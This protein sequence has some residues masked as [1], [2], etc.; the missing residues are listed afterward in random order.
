MSQQRKFSTDVLICQTKA[1]LL[2][3]NLALLASHAFMSLNQCITAHCFSISLSDTVWYKLPQIH[4]N[5]NNIKTS[6]AGVLKHAFNLF[7]LQI[8][9]YAVRCALGSIREHDH[10][11]VHC[12]WV[13]WTQMQVW[14]DW[15]CCTYCKNH[16][17]EISRM[18]NSW[19]A[20]SKVIWCR[21]VWCENYIFCKGLRTSWFIY[22]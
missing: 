3:K 19:A 12:A 21:C 10:Y 22:E 11:M 16:T 14:L 17:A 20:E 18:I 2:L 13:S 5:S 9:F 1:L 8:S 15:K 4:W 6:A 7:V